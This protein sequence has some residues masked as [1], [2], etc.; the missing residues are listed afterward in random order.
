MGKKMKIIK[1]QVLR[2][3]QYKLSDIKKLIDETNCEVH[4]LFDVQMQELEECFA[5]TKNHENP[6]TA[7]DW[8]YYPWSNKIFHLVEES[9]MFFLRTTR[10]RNLITAEEQA[11]LKTISISVAGLS[12]GNSIITGLAYCGIGD[13][14]NIADFDTYS[15]TNM[16][17]VKLRMQDIGLP[18]TIATQRAIH[19]VNPYVETNI[20]SDGVNKENLNE[21]APSNDSLFIFDAID[22]FEMKVRLRMRAKEIRRPLI[23]LT[24]LGDT[25]LVDIERYDVSPDLPYFNGS[26][27]GELIDEILRS[28]SEL[29]LE[30][31]NKFA[32]ELVG[33]EFIPVRALESLKEIGKTIGGRPQLFSSVS[34]DGGLA[35]YAIRTILFN[36]NVESGRYV[37]SLPEILLN[38][39]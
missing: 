16:N 34:M 3:G 36:K 5:D 7:G 2:Q 35:A 25:V 31:I 37:L 23:M 20:F 13:R 11:I 39:I 14:Y 30:K 12:I 18:K 29:S 26:V 22:D 19:E 9:S 27:S 8:V 15:T 38:K 10:N 6:E 33:K 24:S 32:T 4:D 28:G 1:P 21:F 17:R